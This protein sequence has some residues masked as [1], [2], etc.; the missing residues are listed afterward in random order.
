MVCDRTN[1]CKDAKQLD[2]QKKTI[3]RPQNRVKEAGSLKNSQRSG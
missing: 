3:Y 1:A 2:V